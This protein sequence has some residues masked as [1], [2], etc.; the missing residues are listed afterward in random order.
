MDQNYQAVPP[1]GG[2]YA[3]Q[4][5]QPTGAV[6]PQ[7]AP[8][9][10]QTYPPP[11]QA[12]SHEQNY[13]PPQQP[14]YNTQNIPPPQQPPYNPQ[15]FPPPTTAMPS[16]V[17][18]E[19]MYSHQPMNDPHQH[20][21]LPGP[22]PGPPPTFQNSQPP[23]DHGANPSPYPTMAGANDPP[24]PPLP[25]RHGQAFGN[26][27]PSNPI[28]YTRD[29]HKLVAYLV[30][31]PKPKLHGVAPE[32]I[33]D[34]FLIYTPP[35]PPLAKPAEGEKEARLHKVQ[36]KWQEEVR[37]AKTSTAKTASW[38]G[39]KGKA[40][41]GI[42]W[43]M[44]QTVSANLEF[45]NRIGDGTSSKSSK[46]PTHSDDEMEK[47]EH[48]TTHKTV[49]LEEMILVY[50]SSIHGSEQEIRAEF[51]NSMLRSK[52]KAQK[53]TIIA[54]GLLPVGFAIDM[55]AVLIWPFGG[56]A[57]IDAVWLYSSAR[58]AKTARST[59]KR[60]TS[61]STSGNHEE[62][63]LQLRFTPSQRLETLRQY[64]AAECHKRDH[65]LFASAGSVPTETQVLEAI[66]WSPSQSGGESRNW[67]DEQWEMTEVK[68]DFKSV[69]HKGA[70]EWDKWCKAFEKDPEKAMK[71]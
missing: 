68:D 27:D 15:N 23:M 59:T 35:P 18:Q 4:N 49:G 57:E 9:H 66:G 29:P 69:M 62:D 43:A 47:L 14:P 30:P 48:E 56:L 53:D 16:A 46:T 21:D 22:P 32:Q 26:D 38:K 11:Q 70:R 45:L 12:P 61:S 24:G 25:P 19:N 33:P 5:Q 39:V 54:T 65:K 36:R 58:G 10:E 3:P 7:Q 34:R 20:S 1:P 51:V 42:N 44:S 52:S 8:Y 31:F 17:P 67:E 40:T 2:Y 64:L 71:K 41:K 28:H 63:K 13:P 6:P 37:E 50:P 55:L 60:L